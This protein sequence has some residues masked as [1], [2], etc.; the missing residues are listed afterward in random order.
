MFSKLGVSSWDLAHSEFHTA[1]GTRPVPVQVVSQGRYGQPASSTWRAP[2]APLSGSFRCLNR[3]PRDS[4]CQLSSCLTLLQTACAVWH[5]PARVENVIPQVFSRHGNLVR[6]PSQFEH[7]WIEK[8]QNH[9]RYPLQA[10]LSMKQHQR[11]PKLKP[12]ASTC[13]QV[14]RVTGF[15]MAGSANTTGVRI[16]EKQRQVWVEGRGG[17]EGAG[18]RL[19]TN[20]QTKTHQL[21]FL[22]RTALSPPPL[23]Q[24][25]SYDLSHGEGLRSPGF[26]E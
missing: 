19:A 20:Q 11:P 23:V 6:A 26:Y 1:S 24:A 2:R 18:N 5:R 9:K 14:C 16:G 21:C 8:N 7:T 25:A 15:E 12:R 13:G 10:H 17:S 3:S 4:T 22:I